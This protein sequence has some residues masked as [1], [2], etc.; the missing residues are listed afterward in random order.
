M[1]TSGICT[2]PVA[3]LAAALTCCISPPPRSPLAMNPSLSVLLCCEILPASTS[4]VWHLPKSIANFSTG[5]MGGSRWANLL[6]IFRRLGHAGNG[7]LYWRHCASVEHQS[8]G[9]VKSLASPL[10]E[11]LKQTFNV[12][13][14]RESFEHTVLFRTRWQYITL[15]A[16]DKYRIS[17]RKV[18]DQGTEGTIRRHANFD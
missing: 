17:F 8:T 3:T 4:N 13:L 6:R 16:R 15:P 11:Y 5:L 12:L 9:W 2:E 14:A 18:F 1:N 10:Q 7:I